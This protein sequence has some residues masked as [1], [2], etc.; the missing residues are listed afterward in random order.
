MTQN[1]PGI[2]TREQRNNHITAQHDTTRHNTQDMCINLIKLLLD[3]GHKLHELL[4]PKVCEIRNRETRL[5]GESFIILTVGLNV[6]KIVQLSME[7]NN[8]IVI[9]FN[10]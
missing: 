8:I 3:P 7:S 10:S 5:S 6:L 1:N 9:I 4:P 2:G